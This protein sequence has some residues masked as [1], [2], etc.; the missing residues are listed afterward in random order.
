MKFETKDV[1]AISL[2]VATQKMKDVSEVPHFGGSVLP[3]VDEKAKAMNIRAPGAE[4]FIYKFQEGGAFEIRG[5]VPVKTDKG[6]TGEFQFFTAPAVKVI[7][8]IHKGSMPT[9]RQSWDALTQEAKK[10]KLEF[11]NEIREIYLKWVDFDSAENL[12]ELQRVLK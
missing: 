11:T 9:I 2:L 5:G 1:P 12:T 8:C 4:I 7:S 3:K 6:D 10:Q